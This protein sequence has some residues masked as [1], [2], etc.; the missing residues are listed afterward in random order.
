MDRSN[1][2]VS[3]IIILTMAATYCTG[4]QGHQNNPGINLFMERRFAQREFQDQLFDEVDASRRL[5]RAIFGRRPPSEPGEGEGEGGNRHKN[6]PP[7]IVYPCPCPCGS[8][9]YYA[10][11]L[12]CQP[13]CADCPCPCYRGN[14]P[15]GC[16]LRNTC[17]GR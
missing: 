6:P 10:C 3:C 13:S 1:T 2:F 16:I 11:P 15:A 9:S 8:G 4:W 14:C 12:G 5:P 7:K 17:G